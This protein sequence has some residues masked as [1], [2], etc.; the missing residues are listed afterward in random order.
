MISIPLRILKFLFVRHEQ[1]GSDRVRRVAHRLSIGASY[2][3]HWP[4]NA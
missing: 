1:P 3:N 2:R 4:A